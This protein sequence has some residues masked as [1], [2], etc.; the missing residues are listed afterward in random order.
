MPCCA[1]LILLFLGPR[2]AI[3]LFALF[4]T[5]FERPFDGLLLPVL[6]FIFMPWT[7]LAYAWAINSAGQ[8]SGIYLVV[9]ILAALVDLGVVGG[10]ATQ[11]RRAD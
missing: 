5:F 4:S 3:V 2:L 10:G 1:I 6:G 7:L 8:V 11:R 9:V